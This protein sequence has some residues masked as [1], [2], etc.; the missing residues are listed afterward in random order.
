[1]RS[2]AALAAAPASFLVITF[3]FAIF[4]FHGVNKIQLRKAIFS[5]VMHL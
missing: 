3:D 4:C 2:A 1:M 5:R